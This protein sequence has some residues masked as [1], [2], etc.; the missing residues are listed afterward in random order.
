MLVK[1]TEA[2]FFSGNFCYEHSKP[3]N[4]NFHLAVFNFCHC[5]ANFCT[6]IV[7]VYSQL[8]N[9][10]QTNKQTKMQMIWFQ[11]CSLY[12]LYFGEY[13]LLPHVITNQLK[14]LISAS[15]LKKENIVLYRL[16]AYTQSHKKVSFPNA[17]FYTSC[18]LCFRLCSRDK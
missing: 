16:E 13:W 8:R 2:P 1:T 9:V 4:A 12:T 17:F 3:H 5:Y 15:G 7:V 14:M 18:V 6:N 10:K 11:I